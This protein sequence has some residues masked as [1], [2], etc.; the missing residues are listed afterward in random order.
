MEQL[1][2]GLL[3][4]E[5]RLADAVHGLLGGDGPEAAVEEDVARRGAERRLVE[6]GRRRGL[7]VDAALGRAKNPL[8]QVGLC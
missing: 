5:G 8:H 3:E 2:D 1:L 4:L 7:R 6:D